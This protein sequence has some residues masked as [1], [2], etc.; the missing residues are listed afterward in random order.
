MITKGSDMVEYLLEPTN[1][2]PA[3]RFTG[4]LIAKASSW[5]KNSHMW[6]VLKAYK[7]IGGKWVVQSI[8]ETNPDNQDRRVVDVFVFESEEE[9][10]RKIG[11]GRIS[12]KLYTRL[13]FKE[14][15]IG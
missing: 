9:M 8:G 11:H 7:T 13:G 1:G 12:E 10:T 5:R 2:R 3:F 14:I 4:E 15:N 6:T